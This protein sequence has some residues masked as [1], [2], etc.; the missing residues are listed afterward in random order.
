MH[1]SRGEPEQQKE[2]RSI[3]D[4]RRSGTRTCRSGDKIIKVEQRVAGGRM[5]DPGVRLSQ[6]RATGSRRSGAAQAE[7]RSLNYT[8]SGWQRR[9]TGPDGGRDPMASAE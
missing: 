1:V 7:K 9:I 2:S 3:I 6:Y 8:T 4:S 5:S